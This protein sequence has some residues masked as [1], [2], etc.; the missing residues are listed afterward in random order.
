MT[1]LFAR[2]TAVNLKEITDEM[3]ETVAGGGSYRPSSQGV[4]MEVF[5]GFYGEPYVLPSPRGV[6][7]IVT[8]GINEQ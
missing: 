3:A 7:R 6:P 4:D 5:P 8:L 1:R 2:Q